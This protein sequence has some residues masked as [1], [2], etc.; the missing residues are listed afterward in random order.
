MPIL[1]LLFSTT[2]VWA[3][4]LVSNRIAL[5]SFA[6]DAYAMTCW[7]LVFG[8]MALVLIAPGRR[9]PWRQFALPINW[10]YGFLRVLTGVSWTASLLYISAPESGILSQTGMPM[11]AL[12]ATFILGRAPGRSEW[13]GHA[14]LISG[15]L[16]LA[17]HL[18]GGF[19]NPAVLL[20]LASE[21]TAISSSVLAELHP[22]NQVKDTWAHLRFTGV[23]LLITASVFLIAPPVVEFISPVEIPYISTDGLFGTETLIAGLMIGILFRG[24]AMVLTLRSIK[25]AGVEKYIL[26]TSILPFVLL[27][28][29]MLA[30]K[31]DL[32]PTPTHDSVFWISSLLVMIGI[33]QITASKH[34]HA[35]K[36]KRIAAT[37][38][39]PATQSTT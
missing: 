10:A 23:L 5:T 18:P 13:L 2:L 7:Q 38:N 8:G 32:T 33:I 27:G 29:E 25:I 34:R 17:W 22:D 3:L 15:A 28:L 36:T 21:V 39:T 37:A 16:W 1:L 9:I 31:F 26:S 4:M 14:I 11:A 20:M 19:A 12:A 24:P 6:V 30:A 35:A